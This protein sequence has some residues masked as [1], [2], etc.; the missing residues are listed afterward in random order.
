MKLIERIWIDNNKIIKK[1]RN[2]ALDLAHFINL[3]LILI[4]KYKEKY[5][6][7]IISEGVWYSLIA[8]NARKDFNNV[9]AEVLNNILNDK[10]LKEILEQ[11]KQQKERIQNISVIKACL[12]QIRKDF[13]SYFNAL[14]EY[15]NNPSKF[16]GE[17]KPPKPKKLKNITKFEVE[18]TQN[19]FEYPND[20]STIGLKLRIYDKKNKEVIYLKLPFHRRNV[21]SVRM[22]LYHGSIYFD[23]VYEEELNPLKP[24]GNYEA[25]I[26]LG[27]ENFVTLVSNNPKV[28]SI[29]ISGGVL[30]NFNYWFNQKLS[31]YQSNFD[32]IRN[33]VENNDNVD[34]KLVNQYYLWK[35][36]IDKLCI[37]R[38]KWIDNYLHQ[39][40]Q[41]LARFL[42]FTGH[43]KV[44]IGKNILE[45][46]QGS[47]LNSKAN[48]IYY[49]FPY[50]EFIEKLRYK[51]MISISSKIVIKYYQL[52]ILKI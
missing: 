42:Y 51:C 40:S 30:K 24:L 47:E 27:V 35:R 21:T 20:T 17:P 16:T 48:Y 3:M 19:S 7:W 45:A 10:E 6:R 22:I 4:H 52:I 2:L 28:E 37:H 39:V 36:M 15:N 25:A 32:K 11:V 1:C 23:V 18:F 31:L 43:S 38:K 13:T 33:I 14:K 8:N 46:K 41:A 9:K 26:D 5:G 34:Y 44:Y 50:R 12:R 49:K 29:I